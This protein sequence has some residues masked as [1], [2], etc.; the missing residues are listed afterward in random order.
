MYCVKL[1]LSKLQISQF[2]KINNEFNQYFKDLID[3]LYK[4]IIKF[5]LV[6]FIL[7]RVR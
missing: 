3:I 5:E 2:Y 1:A 7:N 4:Y 6:D